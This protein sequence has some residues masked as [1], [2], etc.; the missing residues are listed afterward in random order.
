MQRITFNGTELFERRFNS[1]DDLRSRPHTLTIA[2]LEPV[3]VYDAR[4][5]AEV[6]KIAIH[7]EKAK[8]PFIL[9]KEF[10]DSIANALGEFDASQWIGKQVTVYP[11]PARNGKQTI[12]ARAVDDAPP[13]TEI[14][15]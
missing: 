2:R 8:R 6:D 7:F 13:A 3:K 9:N 10:A 1:A 14:T 15:E 5:R 11:T 4:K 12:L